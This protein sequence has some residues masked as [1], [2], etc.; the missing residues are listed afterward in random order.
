MYLDSEVEKG[1]SHL[2]EKAWLKLAGEL[3]ESV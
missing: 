3:G 2:F 1:S